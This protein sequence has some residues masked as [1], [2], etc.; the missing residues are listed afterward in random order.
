MSATRVAFEGLLVVAVLGVLVYTGYQARDAAGIVEH[1]NRAPPRFHLVGGAPGNSPVKI[2]GGSMTFRAAGW[3]S[4]DGVTWTTPPPNGT[5]SISA[6]TL[7]NVW[8]PGT[9]SGEP[10]TYTYPLPSGW[11]LQIDGRDSTG[12][13]VSGGGNGVL[14][15]QSGGVVQIKPANANCGFYSNPPQKTGGDFTGDAPTYDSANY[16][17]VR[18]MDQSGNCASSKAE[19]ESI[20][21]IEVIVN[22]QPHLFRCPDGACRVYLMSGL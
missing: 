20:W 8:A 22:S 15:T 12:T 11:K 2:V 21:Q 16:V 19:C 1:F 17:G 5:I 3:H 18:Y 13:A 6:V 10:S 14:V 9:T 7:E 4:T